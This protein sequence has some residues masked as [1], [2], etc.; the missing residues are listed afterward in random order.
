VPPST[1]PNRPKD[2]Q[3]LIQKLQTLLDIFNLFVT[4]SPLSWFGLWRYPQ[5]LRNDFKYVSTRLWSHFLFKFTCHTLAHSSGFLTH[6]YLRF[7]FYASF[8]SRFLS[9]KHAFGAG[10]MI[11]HHSR[12]RIHNTKPSLMVEGMETLA[13]KVEAGIRGMS[14]LED[15]SLDVAHDEQS[16]NTKIAIASQMDLEEYFRSQASFTV[17]LRSSQALRTR[18]QPPNR[19]LS[20]KHVSRNYRIRIT[21]VCWPT[22]DLITLKWPP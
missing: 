1:T 16:Q 11:E 13:F 15:I 3:N 6:Q 14:H 20:F 4:S 21:E 5:Q 18:E 9:P 7:P 19:S 2:C 8:F 22:L 12:T 10:V 17:V